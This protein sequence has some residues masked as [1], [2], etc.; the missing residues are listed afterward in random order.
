M[1]SLPV[2][3]IVTP[4]FNQ[5]DYLAETIESV[6]AQDYPNIEYLVLD[7]GSTD[8]T[9]EVLERYRSRI[10]HI[11]HD[12]IGQSR[13]LNKGWELSQGSLL[14]YISSDDR[15]HPKAISTLVNAFDGAP[16]VGVVYGDYRLIDAAGRQIRNVQTEEF[17][18]DRLARDLIC[19]PGP[20]ALFRRD[21]AMASGGFWNTDLTF[22]ADFEFWLRCA[23]HSSIRRAPGILADFRVHAGSGLV[24]PL[25]VARATEMLRVMTA[26]WTGSETDAARRS[27]ANAHWMTARNHAQSGRYLQAVA[28]VRRAARC[29][30]STLARF[31]SWRSVISG[32]LRRSYYVARAKIGGS[33]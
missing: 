6:L 8:S 13:T 28:E 10:T 32:A 24:K 21:V 18:N 3:S 15:L 7:D 1:K 30:A 12:N 2:V 9:P 33:R 27:L 11:R 17:D 19:Q 29:D 5:G 4:A 14:G 23:N 16:E 22:V 26:Y 25:S 20:G 31:S